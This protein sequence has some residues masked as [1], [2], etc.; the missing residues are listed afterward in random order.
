KRTIT[1]DADLVALLVAEREKYLRMVA[2]VPDGTAVDLSLVPLP[3]GALMFP[4]ITGDADLTAP[5]HP[6]NTS[7]AVKRRL[8]ALGFQGMRP[9][10]DLRVTHETSL[11]R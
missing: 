1:I 8:G 11:P 3:D 4:N 5:R 9:F 6:R 7:K 10:H 2:G